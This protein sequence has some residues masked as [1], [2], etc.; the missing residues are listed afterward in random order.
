MV[1]DSSDI[2]FIVLIVIFIATYF[3]FM[4][5]C[6][7]PLLSIE[8]FGIHLLSLSYFYED[9]IMNYYFIIIQ[10][11]FIHLICWVYILFIIDQLLSIIYLYVFN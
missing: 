1:I 4:I 9:F 5:F 2:T 7:D 3:I 8:M 11:I 6:W 10:I